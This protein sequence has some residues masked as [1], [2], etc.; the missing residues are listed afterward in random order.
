MRIPK[1]SD[2]MMAGKE[3]NSAAPIQCC[4]IFLSN[5][6]KTSADTTREIDLHSGPRNLQR[7]PAGKYFRRK[8]RVGKGI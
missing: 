2:Y 4:R 5:Y 1:N 3:G 8:K 7:Q 6:P